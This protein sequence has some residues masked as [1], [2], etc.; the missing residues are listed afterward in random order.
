MFSWHEQL[1]NVI[2]I[3]PQWATT[4]VWQKTT[5]V[6]QVVVRPHRLHAVY[7][8]Q[9]VVTD[10]A[11]VCVCVTNVWAV[12]KRLN[13]SRC[14]LEEGWGGADSCGSKEPCFRWGSRS[15]QS[16]CSYEGFQVGDVFFA[17]LLWTLVV[18]LLLLDMQRLIMTSIVELS[19][20]I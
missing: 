16:V 11:H 18:L 8:M 12:P 5:V 6:S 17:N 1:P 9:F 3:G 2:W 20:G 10:V 19:L 13:Q 7:E 4:S 15:D 14:R